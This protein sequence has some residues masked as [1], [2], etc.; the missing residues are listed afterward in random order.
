MESDDD[1]TD[2]E[3]S[4]YVTLDN[5]EDE[6]EEKIDDDE[7]AAFQKIPKNKAKQEA[8]MRALKKV[9]KSPKRM[10]KLVSSLRKK[11]QGKSSTRAKRIR[12]QSKGSPKLPKDLDGEGGSSQT[13]K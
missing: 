1:E 11:E 4:E 9:M 10:E 6:G 3:N 13:Q 2:S 12:R 5:T 7:A 8:L